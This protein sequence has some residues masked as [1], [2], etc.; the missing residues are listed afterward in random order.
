MT[1]ILD[2][3][4]DVERELASKAEA[5]GLSLEAFAGR[6]LEEEARRRVDPKAGPSLLEASEMVRGLLTDEEVDTLFAR[7][8]EPGRQVHFE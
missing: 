6:L 5:S 2:L 7:N 3:Q 8:K 4:P 1:L